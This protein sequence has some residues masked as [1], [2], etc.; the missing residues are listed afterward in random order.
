MLLSG[1]KNRL[2]DSK[3]ILSVYFFFRKIR[4]QLMLLKYRRLAKKQH[5]TIVHFLHIGKTGGSSIKYGLKYKGKPYI[6]NQFIIICQP[7]FFKLKDTRAGEK[8]FFIVRDPVERF[9]SGFYSR[10]RKGQPRIYSEW[11]ANEKT[12]FETFNTPNELAVAISSKNVKI[13]TKAI[14]AMKSITHI[15]TS[16]WD[17]FNNKSFFLNRL[18]DIFFIGNQENLGNDFLIL[19]KK[20]EL[21][22]DYALP[23]DE[24]KQH[25]N[26]E[27]VDKKISPEGMENL[28]VWYKKDYEFLELLKKDNLL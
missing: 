10:K 6:H 15:N 13:K 24:I 5:K 4:K 17:W 9:I 1:L 27:D 26:P 23:D 18:D 7:H 21:P 14:M 12:A 11:S 2:K 19:K 8:F 3:F 25:K 22:D 28:K 20:L 16:Y